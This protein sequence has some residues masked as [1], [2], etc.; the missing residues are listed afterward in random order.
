MMSGIA[1]F[2]LT[3]VAIIGY[4]HPWLKLWTLKKH[5]Y[6]LNFLLFVSII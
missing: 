6:L 4:G 1:K 3:C 5:N 2:L